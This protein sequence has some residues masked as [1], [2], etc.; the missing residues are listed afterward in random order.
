MYEK[1]IL[2]SD[3][4]PATLEIIKCV[5]ILKTVGM[6]EVII[7]HALGIKYL[8]TM[9]YDLMRYA[10]P[11][12]LEEKQALEKLSYSVKIAVCKNG[13]AW[14]LNKVFEKEKAVLVIIGSHGAGMSFDSPIGG[15]AEKILHDSNVPLL[16][17]R[18]QKLE[19]EALPR[20]KADCLNFSK[21]ILYVT[22]FS[23]TSH[24]AFTH[25]ENIVEA[26]AHRIALLHVQDKTKIEKHLLTR[27]EE[28]NRMDMSRLEMLKKALIS[29]GAREVEI[30]LKYGV[31][32]AEILKTSMEDDYTL[33]VMGSQGRGYIKEIFLGSVSDNVVRRATIPVLL[34]PAF[35]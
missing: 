28:F 27:L 12:L 20:C 8:D 34:I 6:K 10:E 5:G 24:R 19:G 16:I 31:P 33:I 17:I 2:A 25:L 32:V 22:D 26:G 11:A 9:Q 21:K 15:T 30:L 7:F 13:T 18:L 29:K 35:R 14:E 3:L 1:F 23:D 4:S